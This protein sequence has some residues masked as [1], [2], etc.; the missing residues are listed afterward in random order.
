M[1]KRKASFGARSAMKKYKPYQAR[2]KR[3]VKNYDVMPFKIR[4]TYE[5]T[6]NASGEIN[7]VV[8]TSDPESALG[9]SG[10]YNDWTTLEALWDSYKVTGLRIQFSPYHPNGGGGTATRAQR[11]LYMVQDRDDTTALTSYDT[12]IQ[13]DKVKIK[14]L[15]KP[16]DVFFKTLDKSSSGSP[17]GWLNVGNA[18]S[19]T[20]R[21]SSVKFWS[22][23][24]T[25]SSDYGRVTLT[26]YIKCAGRR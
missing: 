8:S 7:N 18:G 6:S 17:V 20:N 26:M 23:G 9:G 19:A 13:Y 21:I 5:I 14:A 22:E 16:F 4:Y 25:A 15:D 11:P 24:L 10:T 1:A 2:V 3:S 12:A